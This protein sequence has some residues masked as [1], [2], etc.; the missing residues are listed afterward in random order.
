MEM[1][2]SRVLPV[3]VAQAW[4]ALND[5]EILKASIPGC[6]RFEPDPEAGPNVWAMGVKVKIGPVSARFTGR[7]TLADVRP[8]EGYT[9]LFE[10]QGGAAGFGKGQAAVELAPLEAGCELRYAVKSTIGGKL[11]QIGQRLIDAAAKS[12]AEDFFKRF[13]AVLRERTGQAG[14]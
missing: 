7:I 9:L 5:P 11:A 6:E 10:A 1:Q 4:Q 14:S 12:L 13:E 2:A 3:S 8:A